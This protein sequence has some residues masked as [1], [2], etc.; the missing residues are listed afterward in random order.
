MKTQPDLCSAART[1]GGSAPLTFLGRRKPVLFFSPTR[2]KQMKGN[3]PNKNTNRDCP[4][5][6]ERGQPWDSGR[7]LLSPDSGS[8]TAVL[9]MS[10]L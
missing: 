6:E 3:A 5:W 9:A 4:L 10:L 7:A 1:G 8:L 2:L